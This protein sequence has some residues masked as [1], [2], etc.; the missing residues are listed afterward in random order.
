MLTKTF[1][2]NVEQINR[3]YKRKSP[4]VLLEYVL[5]LFDDE[6]GFASSFGAE[7]VVIIDMISKIKANAYI[8]TL[9]TGRLPD[10]T[11]D[12][13]E[14]IQK[15]YGIKIKS[16]YPDAAAV[17]KM[18]D[19][20]GPNLFYKSIELRKLC[21]K[22]RKIEPLNRALDGLAA[23]ICGLRREQSITRSDLDL[24]EIDTAHNGIFKFNPLIDWTEKDVWDYIRENEVPYNAL[25]DRNYPSIGCEPCT[26]AVKSI[27]D[28]RAGRWWWEAPEHKECGLHLKK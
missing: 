16:F 13:M 14:R 24:V 1:D 25:H 10:E 4:E 8:F 23:W 18:I 7:D 26:R 21:C 19:T 15:K 11:Y 2:L 28:F 9:D 6:I 12:V 27:E 3:E 17:E 22:V 5:N 20:Y